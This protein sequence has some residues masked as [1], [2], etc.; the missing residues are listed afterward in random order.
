M[1]KRIVFIFLAVFLLVICLSLSAEKKD[2]GWLSE[3]IE[4]TSP[5]RVEAALSLRGRQGPF[6]NHVHLDF[7]IHSIN[8]NLEEV[9]RLQNQDLPESEIQVRLE[10]G[11]TAYGYGTITG[12]LTEK[13]GANIQDSAFIYAY[14]KF[15]QYCGS[16]WVSSDSGSQY[17]IQGLSPGKY[18]VQVR[19]DYYQDVYYR[20]TP[21][22]KKAKLVRVYNYK[23]TSNINFKLKVN[24]GK[25]SISG[26]VRRKDKAP[27]MD[28]EVSLYDRKW[29]MVK[30]A[31]T[32]ADGRYIIE[33]LQAGDYK[34]R[35]TY[36]EGDVS[37]RIWYGNARS[38]E[39]AALVT[40]SD[41]EDLKEIDFILEYCGSIEGKV[42]GSNGRPVQ[43]SLCAIEA[44]DRN[45]N[46]I[47]HTFTNIKGEFTL[48]ALPKGRYRLKISYGGVANNVDCWYKNAKRF[49][50]AKAISVTPFQKTK[51]NIKLK[52]GGTISGTAVD[53]NGQVIAH[54]CEILVYDDSYRYVKNCFTDKKGFFRISGLQAGRYKVFA[55]YSDYSGSPGP[56]PVSEWYGGKY[57]YHEAP[58]VRVATGKNSRNI[59]F[60]LEKGGSITGTLVDPYGYPFDYG[61]VVYVFNKM[62]EIVGFAEV[63]PYQGEYEIAG[64]P[65]GE[66]Q[67]EAVNWAD[68]DYIEEWYDNKKSFTSA[69]RIAVTAPNTTSNI[70]IQLGYRGIIK[71][72]VTDRKKNRLTE[73]N[74]IIQLIAF[75]ASTGEHAYSA[76]NNFVGGYQLELMEGTYKIAAVCYYTNWLSNQID[77]VLTFHLD[78][79]SFNDPNT[80]IFSVL[81]ESSKSIKTLSLK[82]AKGAIS[83]TLYNS[84]TGLPITRGAYYVF[85][86]DEHGYFAGLSFYDETYGPLSGMYHVGGLRPGQYYLLTIVI[87]EGESINHMPDQWYNGVELTPEEQANI[88][89]KIDIPAG[90]MTVTVGSEPTKGIDFYLKMPKKK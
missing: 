18:Y 68:E 46:Y 58:F 21:D 6:G 54:K 61:G 77:F 73:E 70:D 48:A 41:S 14:N 31:K 53:F 86:F 44:Y 10:A 57:F 83:G 59:D 76:S 34:L 15:G 74:P 63:D 79:R 82:K 11:Q 5:H 69:D 62:Y 40:L 29:S 81:P 8:A 23:T 88:S 9:A 16:D 43:T 24:E 60:S 27:M 28:C 22:W 35:C 1:N 47:Q 26:Q 52:R 67:L 55:A 39:K 37:M 30:S 50:S 38:F 72:F 32:G 87:A 84:R 17:R 85:V 45:E 33:N 75:D 56:N 49:K 25:S 65:S 4:L 42:I 89:P 19:S 80:K 3:L 12:T 90:A 20:N 13:G 71:G 64:L 7:A 78:R 2:K 36:K 51:V 66:Y